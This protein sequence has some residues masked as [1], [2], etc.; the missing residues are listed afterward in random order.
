MHEGGG[1]VSPLTGPLAIATVGQFC[2]VEASRG[3]RCAGYL[4]LQPQVLQMELWITQR[5]NGISYG[6]L[7]FLL[8]GGLSLI[9]GM[10]R[11][12]NMT[13]GSYYLLRGYVGL[14]VI[15][16]SGHFLLAILAGAVAI[17]L[18]GVVESWKIRAMPMVMGTCP[19]SC[20]PNRRWW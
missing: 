1:S 13:H 4:L 12:V 11:I 6:A 2:P 15:W 10:T 18:L 19:N 20:P 5:F 16:Q 3:T 14:T 7:L 9:F 17:A 8:A